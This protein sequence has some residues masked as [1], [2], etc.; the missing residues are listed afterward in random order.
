[1]ADPNTRSL[2]MTFTD[3]AK[4]FARTVIPYLVGLVIAQAFRVGL[5]LHGYEAQVTVAVGTVY[6]AAVRLAEHYLSLR[7]GWL[8]G[9]A[10]PPIYGPKLRR[11]KVSPILPS[12]WSSNA[13]N[14]NLTW[15]ANTLPPRSIHDR[16]TLLPKPSG[17]KG[18]ALPSPRDDRDYPAKLPRPSAIPSSVD[19]GAGI[20]WRMLLNDRLGDCYEAA[21]LHALQVLTGYTPTDADALAI[22]EQV[23]GYDPTKTRPDG[24]NPTDRGTAGRPLFDWARRQ[25]L[26]SSYAAAPA[27]RSAVKAAIA[28]H[29]VVLCEWALPVGAEVEGDVWTLPR[30]NRAAG[31]WGYHATVEVGYTTR[32]N[33]N[34][35][36]GEEGSV[37]PAF[38]DAYL[39]AAWVITPAP[40]VD[41]ASIMTRVRAG[42]GVA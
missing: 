24:S 14:A 4:S 12:R 30:S 11:L 7:F 38:E 9:V 2:V 23:T 29:K 26:I 42:H 28:A 35:T 8:L 40:G 10:A 36:W 41:V 20:T 31:S 16:L 17:R 37:T 5:D 39:Q 34:V 3:L 18:G 22:Y 32:R 27:T 15:N 19:N 1:M 33:R 21:F 6:Y 25:G 13:P